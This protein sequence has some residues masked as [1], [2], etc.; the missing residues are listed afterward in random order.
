[1]KKEA[2]N[3][4]V[5]VKAR[6]LTIAKTSGKPYDELL[7]LFGMERLLYRFSK[8]R[9]KDIL[10]L[11]GALFF[12]IRDIPDRR[13]TLDIDFLARY[14]NSPA[15]IKGIIKGICLTPVEDDGIRYDAGAITAAGIKEAAEYPGVRV[16]L[17]AYIERTQIPV[18][19]DFGFGDV[20]YPAAK[21]VKYPVLLNFPA[22]K[23]KGYPPESVI[24]EK[25]ESIIRLGDLN[26][27]M[28]DFYD[29]WLIFRNL[30]L[31]NAEVAK[32]IKKTFNN[33]HT[34]LPRANKLF[35]ED[36]YGRNSDRQQLWN[37][38]LTKNDIEIAPKFLSDT[39][40]EIEKQL[41]KS[42]MIIRKGEI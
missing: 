16:K 14:D 13:T 24:S 41:L 22:P 39:A 27:R 17:V 40:A 8:S 38:F 35:S 9:F 30:K 32:A 12:L 42:V 21:K 7:K 3:V 31:K 26:S 37:A 34:I 6:L 2:K 15:K 5:S 4:A 25:F 33:R 19:I 36:I 29:I 18:Q 1:M 20:V 10:I 28:K 11:K 23:L